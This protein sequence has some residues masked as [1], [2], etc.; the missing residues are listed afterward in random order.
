MWSAIVGQQRT[1][2]HLLESFYMAGLGSFE[3]VYVENEWYDGPRVGL[4]DIHGVPHR[5][6]SLFDER[7]DE[8]LST[9]EV[10]PISREELEL[11][12]E[13][14][15]IFVEWNTRYES[16]EAD[17]DSHP[18]HGG[19]SERWDEIESLVKKSRTNVPLNARRARA[20]LASA[21]REHRYEVTGPNYLMCWEFQ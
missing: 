6:N 9:F 1:L 10:W 12:I 2:K 11:E 4:A 18:G 13:Q 8:Y 15:C 17:T 19:L 7:E 14:W 16:G 5:F 20:Q 3:R 21:N